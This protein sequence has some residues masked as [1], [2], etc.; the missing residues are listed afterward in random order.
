M[1]FEECKKYHLPLYRCPSFIFFVLGL[2]NIFSILT[3]YSIANKIVEDPRIVALICAFLASFILI[4]SYFATKTLEALAES[5]RI[6]SEFVTIASHQLKTPISNL[7]FALEILMSGKKGKIE[8]EQVEYFQ[9]LKEN[10]N[11]LKELAKDLLLVSKIEAGNFKLKKEE[12]DL[13]EL[14][15]S[16]VKNFVLFAKAHNVE[17][18]CDFEKDLPKVFADKEQIKDVIET[19]LDNAI[20]YSK[21][22][23]NLVEIKICKKQKEIYFEIKDQGI[24]IPKKDQKYLFEKFFRGSNVSKNEIPGTGLGLFI[25]KSIIERSGGKINLKSEE[26]KGTTVSFTLPISQK[27]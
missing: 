20:K 3:S 21:K 22:E 25:A 17:I 24:G 10:T 6:K 16:V 13:S 23:K 15:E 18:K 1:L 19:L 4:L 27:T 9:I 7:K 11:R 5:N 8:P 2:I 14:T 26:N 12:F